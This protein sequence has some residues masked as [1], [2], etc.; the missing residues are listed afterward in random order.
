MTISGKDGRDEGRSDSDAKYLRILA[1]GV[2]SQAYFDEWF[3]GARCR[4]NSFE[5]CGENLI[6]KIAAAGLTV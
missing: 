1:W 2:R 5:I 6:P 3:T 4:R